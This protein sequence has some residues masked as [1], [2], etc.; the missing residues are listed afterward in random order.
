MI[1]IYRTLFVRGFQQLEPLSLLCLRLAVA[2]VFWDSGVT[3]WNGFFDFNTAKFDLFLY[4]FFCPKPPR[5]GALQLCDPNTLEY[6][7]GSFT[8]TAVKGL[9]VLAGV[10]EIVL[11]VLLV[12]GLLSR[13]SAL[14]L[15]GMTIFIQLAVFPSWEHWW[16]PAVWWAVILL[17]LITRGPGAWSLD[18]L[19]RLEGPSRR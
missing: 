12:V 10:V 9:A 2:K 17:L 7:Q 18:H 19:L 5:A 16:N 15:F 6:T 1:S 11:P 13:L 4:E 3:K 8:V 14:G